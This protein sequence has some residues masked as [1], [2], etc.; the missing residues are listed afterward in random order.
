MPKL[1]ASHEQDSPDVLDSIMDSAV[2]DLNAGIA[3]M[4]KGDYAKAEKLI[5]ASVPILEMRDDKVVLGRGYHHL[6]L[7]YHFAGRPAEGIVPMEKAV[8][9]RHEAKD[10]AVLQS[11]CCLTAL[12]HNSGNLDRAIS[13]ARE[14]IE[15]AR[16]RDDRPS[17]ALGLAG[18]ARAFVKTGM[19]NE[20]CEACKAFEEAIQIVAASKIP[21]AQLTLQQLKLELAMAT[22][23]MPEGVR[24]NLQAVTRDGHVPPRLPGESGSGGGGSACAENGRE[25]P[26]EVLRQNS[27][28]E[29]PPKPPETALQQRAADRVPMNSQETVASASEFR[30]PNAEPPTELAC[31]GCADA[32][33]DA[34]SSERDQE[35]PARTMLAEV[36]KPICP[37]CGKP[38]AQAQFCVHC[39]QALAKPLPQHPASTAPQAEG[40]DCT[41]GQSNPPGNRF[42]SRCGRRL[43]GVGPTTCPKCHATARTG[44]AFCTRCGAKMEP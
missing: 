26:R 36:S 7:T 31:S 17:L 13:S 1:E 34:A 19:Q 5:K 42:C 18:L 32:P 3:E 43:P 15:L 25:P 29:A 37:S 21:I 14:A 20:L 40:K 23:R 16:G 27:E 33:A 24:K 35:E 8:R 22:A 6:A 10:P 2:R 11:L 38:A 41:C 44:V 4:R 9:I 12:C 39:G 30:P 28:M